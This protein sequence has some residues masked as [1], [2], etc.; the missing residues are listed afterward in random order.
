MGN[1]FF[2]MFFN[3]RLCIDLPILFVLSNYY[4]QGTHLPSILFFLCSYSVLSAN[5]FIGTIPESF[6]NLKNLKDLLVVKLFGNL[7]FFVN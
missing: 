7:S 5:N 6:H 4:F 1:Y 3:I 2:I